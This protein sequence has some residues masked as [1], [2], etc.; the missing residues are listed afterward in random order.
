MNQSTSKDTRPSFTSRNQPKNGT[1]LAR[2][3][4]HLDSKFS[5]SLK[6][7]L[8]AS[9]TSNDRRDVDSSFFDA[10]YASPFYGVTS[11]TGLGSQDD[12]KNTQQSYGMWFIPPD[13]DT[14]VLVTF[15]EGSADL[16][17]WFAC[18]PDDFMNFM[19]PDG[20]PTTVF[21]TPGTSSQDGRRLPVGEFNKNI[22]DPSGNQQPTT[23]IKPVN[24]DFVNVL[25]D[26]GLLEDDFR[27]LTSSS[28]RREIPSSVFGINTPGP[29]DKRPGSPT[30]D[31]G[32]KDKSVLVPSSRLTGHSIVMDDGDD[33]ILRK[34]PAKD[35]PAEYIAVETSRASDIPPGSEMFPANE[36][37]RIR[38][39]TGHQ[40]LLHNTEDLIYIAN[41]RGTAWIELSSNGKIDVFA[42]DSISF[43][44]QQ[45]INF[46][47]DRDI[48]FTAGNNVN[49]NAT[50]EF[51]NTVGSNYD[52]TAGGHIATNSA[53]STTLESGT[54]SA[55]RAGTGTSIITSA[56][57]L[58]LSSSN[59]IKSKALGEITIDSNTAISVTTDGIIGLKGKAGLKIEA[60]SYDS[61]IDG[62]S[63]TT[64]IGDSH[65]FT[66]GTVNSWSQGDTN[67]KA[68][69]NMFVNTTGGSVHTYSGDA[70]YN[71]AVAT[72]NNKS[73]QSIYN[74]AATNINLKA[75]GIV[76]IDAT[77]Q[78]QIQANLAGDATAATE[79]AS[80]EL[81]A[82]WSIDA[83]APNLDETITPTPAPIAARVPMH[84]PWFGH[85]NLNPEAF[86]PS[87]TA[88]GVEQITS[89]PTPLMDT[90]NLIGLNTASET[91]I[92][93]S[94]RAAQRGLV[95]E[96][97]SD[98]GEEDPVTFSS[99]SSSTTISERALIA[100]AF[101]QE[102]TFGSDILNE[103][104]KQIGHPPIF[105]FTLAQA[106]GIVGAMQIE[107]G[108]TLEPGAWNPKG[109][110]LGA[111]GLVQW[112]NG[113]KR[114]T[115][116]EQF[117]GK[118]ILVQNEMDV[119][120]AG[121]ASMGRSQ[122][123]PVSETRANGVKVGLVNATFEDQLTAIREELNG[124]DIIAA[125]NVQRLR[126]NTGNGLLD[127]SNTALA[128]DRFFERSN[129][130]LRARQQAATSLFTNF[131]KATQSTGNQQ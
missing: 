67:I 32:P 65:L 14:K 107:S 55:F 102:N 36:L 71:Y 106:C 113:G 125:S 1:Y 15:V 18:V 97:D 11:Y 92:I 75:A 80:A 83:D 2:V 28:A 108:N 44:T 99:G 119:F 117:L 16:C 115:L 109:G 12:F 124:L 69:T 49:I 131:S 104:G 47:A 86:A 9:T 30:I 89:T 62:S 114:L 50:S 41:A 13:I 77:G 88:A 93:S 76:A 95:G 57:D 38:T 94:Q 51:K 53:E 34:G 54:F 81:A 82:E 79:A 19:I 98:G 29:M 17:Y 10:F 68:E 121:Y 118:P 66:T 111:R 3:V 105:K 74:Q 120:A 123:G 40:I 73:D 4:S 84:E 61:Y 26:A 42:A 22:N 112:R 85:E 5:G 48:N 100:I 43:H 103:E 91:R 101:F 27:G 72:I 31:R 6:V 70:I 58:N 60:I 127:A 56:G 7:Q 46:T 21:T 130:K 8:L 39:R 25:T 33:K 128:W 126:I 122:R 63:R 116:V 52:L 45:D 90:F 37:F 59:A 96:D 20:R 64:V 23:Y 129:Q 110:G 78:I 24:Q 87:E 35:T